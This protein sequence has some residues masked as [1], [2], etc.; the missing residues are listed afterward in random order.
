MTEPRFD[1]D[2][3]ST[4]APTA[5][6]SAGALLRAA[7]ERQGLHIAA[8]AAA[9]KVSPKKLEALEADRWSDL[10]DA[11]FTRALAQTVCR[12]LKIDARIVLDKLPPAGGVNLALTLPSDTETGGAPAGT[13]AVSAGRSGGGIPGLAW[14]ALLLLVGAG[15]LVALPSG[16]TLRTAL[17]APPAATSASAPAPGLTAASGVPAAAASVAVAPEPPASAAF[18]PA[19]SAPWLPGSSAAPA[20]QSAPVVPVAAAAAPAPAGA[21]ALVFTASQD[22]WIEVRDASGAVLVSRLLATGERMGLDGTPPLRVTIGNAT[23]TQLSWRG[24]SIDIV[25]RQQGN[26]ARVDLP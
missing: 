26:V 19:A 18:D 15:V 6:P 10:P 3:G 24:Q 5:A 1:S 13:S 22:S 21:G 14:G 2:S 4:A 8:L 16:W 17:P 7:R 12:T 11:T 20:P 25:S 9:I 23:G